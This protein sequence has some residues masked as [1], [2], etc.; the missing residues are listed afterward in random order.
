MY[1]RRPRDN[2]GVGEHEHYENGQ[3]DPEPRRG[4]K[5]RE[6][7]RVAHVTRLIERPPHYSDVRLQYPVRTVASRFDAR[8]LVP[9]A[10]SSTKIATLAAPPGSCALD[11]REETSVSAHMNVTRMSKSTQSLDEHLEGHPEYNRQFDAFH[12]SE[13][14][15]PK[16]SGAFY[17]AGSTSTVWQRCTALVPSALSSAKIAT[18]GAPL[19]SCALDV[20][21]ETSV[22]AHMNVT[23]MSRSTQSLDEH[24]DGRPKYK[25]KAI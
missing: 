22:S 25:Y 4:A 13:S 18:L 16:G 20:R 12:R 3:I 1:A 8:L 23:R 14:S 7:E 6:P 2:L 5:P 10:H 11:V 17:Q 19:G 15:E 9:S 21:K 24:L